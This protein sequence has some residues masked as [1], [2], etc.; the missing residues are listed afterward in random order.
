MFFSV[1]FFSAPRISYR[2]PKNNPCRPKINLIVFW[3]WKS[4]LANRKRKPQ[5]AHTFFWHKKTMSRFFE[6]VVFNIFCTYRNKNRLRQQTG[7]NNLKSGKT[8][9]LYVQ[10][11][12]DNYDV[13]YM[14]AIQM[15]WR[16]VLIIFE[17]K[18]INYDC[19]AFVNYFKNYQIMQHKNDVSSKM[20]F[21]TLKKSTV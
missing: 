10:I 18:F 8:T 15:L 19:I 13:S 11:C 20:N 3:T 9:I 5:A 1:R 6:T 4:V 21:K 16:F 2:V 14:I 17:K 12:I 7:L